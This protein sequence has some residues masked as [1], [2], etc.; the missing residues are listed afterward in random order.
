MALQA[1][2]PHLHGRES[3]KGLHTTTTATIP[4]SYY[5]LGFLQDIPSYTSRFVCASSLF[6][7]AKRTS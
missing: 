3:L 4:T 1:C 5:C 6:F 7:A 2:L